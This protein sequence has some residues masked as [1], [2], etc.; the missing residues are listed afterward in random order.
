MQQSPTLLLTGATGLLG[1]HALINLVKQGLQV[2]AL[3]RPDSQYRERL[4]EIFNLYKL[5][6][7]LLNSQV[8]FFEG[9]MLDLAA[10]ED[11]LIG[12]DS[13]IHCAASVRNT[14]KTEMNNINIEGTSNLVNLC[15]DYSIKW[16]LHVSSVAT[17][18]P[19]PEGL[20]DEDYFFKFNP[21]LS[22]YALSKYRAEQEVWRAIEEGLP[23]VIINPTYIIGASKS[24]TSSSAIFKY[25]KQGIPFYTKG[26]GGYVDV[27]DVAEVI[28]KLYQK[29][30][31]GKRYIVSAENWETFDFLKSVSQAM[32]SNIPKRAY[33]DW[34]GIPASIFFAIRKLFTGK[35]ATFDRQVV[36]MAQSRNAYDSSR[37][38]SETG[39]SFKPIKDS[40]LVTAE[41][42]N[43]LMA[44]N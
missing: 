5:D 4:S 3:V 27:S 12:I 10:L 17:L 25:A 14:D 42:M 41:Y 29:R 6:S 11:A 43:R 26:L 2:R 39:I 18:G 13:V 33:H 1:S 34:M 31:S 8:E 37:I 35:T 40:I 38:V 16:F 30:I 21:R 24:D 36:R 44:K 22:N 7:S 19:N 15:L 28:S 20:V 9:D 32:H 23:A